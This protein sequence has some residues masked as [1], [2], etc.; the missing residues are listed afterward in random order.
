MTEASISCLCGES[1]CRVKLV[2]TI[3]VKSVL[4]HQSSCRHNLGALCH[5][6][7]PIKTRPKLVDLLHKYQCDEVSRYFCGTCGSHVFEHDGVWK[8]QSG[9]VVTTHSEQISHQLEEVTSHRY[10]Q[11]T[12]DGG[13]SLCFTG[14]DGHKEGSQTRTIE[15]PAGEARAACVDAYTNNSR[16]GA[17]GRLSAGCSCGGVQFFVTRPNE[18]SRLC[19]SPWP[20][21]IVPYH[22]GSSVNPH[23]VKW[24]IRDRG[25]WLAGTCACKSCKLAL[26]SPIQAWT[27]VSLT[28]L[29]N[30]DGTPLSYTHGTLRAFESSKDTI[31][32]FCGTCG[33]TVFWHNLERPGVVD[34]SVGVLR[35][36]EGAMARNWLEW[37]TERV[38]FAEEAFDTQLIAQLGSGLQY[39]SKNVEYDNP[40]Q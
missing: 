34:V 14:A 28:N 39:L 31:R 8:V 5:T 16:E 29:H 12:V 24:W 30:P 35:A 2:D 40:L 33:A 25:K 17:Q 4:C 27:F 21:L 23:D 10:V 26:G 15:I 13:L 38:S 37:W 1:V 19:S 22:S 3:P 7:I 32:E 6:A 20:D 36:E 11:D 9:V 18:Q